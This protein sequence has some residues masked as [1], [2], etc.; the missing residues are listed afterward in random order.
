MMSAM[1]IAGSPLRRTGAFGIAAEPLIGSAELA[2][3][4]HA[5]AVKISPGFLRAAAA[6][7]RRLRLQAADP[8]WVDMPLGVPLMSTDRARR[9]LGWEA[10]PFGH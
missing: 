7:T 2:Q 3:R 1:P 6:A 4:L 10:A 5:Q 9:E 8:G